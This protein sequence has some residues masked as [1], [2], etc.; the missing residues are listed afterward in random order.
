MLKAKSTKSNTSRRTFIKVSLAGAAAWLPDGLIPDLLEEINK[1]KSPNDKD[2]KQIR[3][4]FI[5]KKGVTYMN[6][7][8]LGMPPL[9][10]VQAVHKGYEAISK[11][12]LHGKHDLQEAIR[13]RVIPGLAETFG[14]NDDEIVLTRNASE[15]LHLQ[16]TALK[17]KKGDEVIITTQEHPAG[18][19]P[20]MFRQKQD[21]INV[22]AVFIPSPLTS[23]SDVLD[24][25][26]STISPLTKAISFCHVTRGG[27][28]Y[29]IKKIATWAREKGIVT[30]VDGAQ[31]I[32]QFPLNIHD[33]GCDAYAV[34]LHKWVLA[35]A[36]TGF[37]YVRKE[38]RDRFQSPFDPNPSTDA[39]GFDPPGT[40][41]FPTRAAINAAL[42]FINHIG[43]D[44]VEERCRYLSDHLKD[45]L[46]QIDG[47]T[48]LSG[49]THNLSAPGST[50]FEKEGLDAMA[51]VP[52]MEQK[53]NTH[54]DE[55]QR[56]GHNAIRVSTHIYNT[57][58]EINRLLNAL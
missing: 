40:K 36:G 46:R 57:T 43:L 51:A 35:P 27:H 10:V 53:I 19:R 11:E 16:T 1:P 5:L 38:S 26:N 15:A 8:S 49:N 21:G 13:E 34:S 37:F 55:H 14:T 58:A 2:W 54:I 25:F 18:L 56:D 24:R 17:L 48:I 31:A 52:L 50:I 3:S 23:E 32:G 45:G 6:N 39:P 12:P 9:S 4:Q 44:Q 30:L 7:A 47:V 20:W 28:L 33:L 41:D 22:K 42:G 29:P